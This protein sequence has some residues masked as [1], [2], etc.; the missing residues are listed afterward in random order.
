MQMRTNPDHIDMWN[1]GFNQ[2]ILILSHIFAG[3]TVFTEIK[4]T[5]SKNFS[6]TAYTSTCGCL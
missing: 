5:T 1:H 6:L 4:V 2:E 3:S